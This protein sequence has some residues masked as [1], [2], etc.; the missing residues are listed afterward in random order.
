[1]TKIEDKDLYGLHY[2]VG[3]H[4]GR[5]L[6]L[7]KRMAEHI[8]SI[9][10]FREQKLNLVCRGSSGAII[11]G[12]LATILPNKIRISHIKKEGE[13]SHHS[14]TSFYRDEYNIIVDD[15]MASG[16]TLNAIYE[17]MSTQPYGTVDC[18][19]IGGKVWTGNLAFKPTFV[20]CKVVDDEA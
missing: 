18:L 6:P 16:R 13:Q 2:P 7:I 17:Y 15:L 5:N 3:E 1:M 8:M 14:T 9:G 20:I 19:C 10:K 11:S 12:V 4:I